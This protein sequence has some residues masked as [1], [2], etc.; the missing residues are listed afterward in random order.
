[1]ARPL[2]C[3]LVT[4]QN[5]EGVSQKVV[6]QTQFYIG[7]ATECAL[8]FA[9]LNISRHH[10]LVKVKGSKV[11][12][13]DQ[14]SSNGTYLNNERLPKSRLMPVE[15]G[16]RIRLGTAGA[17]MTFKPVEIAFTE[18]L[19][20][21]SSLKTEDKESALNMIHGAHAEAARLVSVG[22]QLHDKYVQNAEEKAAQ[23]EQK[24]A[25]NYDHVIGE[26]SKQAKTMVEQARAQHDQLLASAEQ[27]AENAT[28]A[29][30]ERM[31]ADAKARAART[32][33]EARLSA[34]QILENARIAAEDL[35]LRRQQEA[36]IDAR[37]AF[38]ERKKEIQVLQ[39]KKAADIDR[40]RERA[41]ES[42]REIIAQENAR[43]ESERMRLQKEIAD[44]RAESDDLG[45]VVQGKRGDLKAVE[46]Q[47]AATRAEAALA[48]TGVNGKQKEAAALEE[49]INALKAGLAD[50]NEHHGKRE[51]VILEV[52]QLKRQAADMLAAHD[53]KIAENKIAVEEDLT[54]RRKQ[55]EE[56]L[57]NMRVAE[58]ER[59][60]RE[61]AAAM[62]EL[63]RER[64]RLGQKIFVEIETAA[65]KSIPAE[66]WRRAAK[67]VEEA[68]LNNL[69][70]SA[71]SESSSEEISPLIA[72]VVK[73]RKRARFIHT[74]QGLALG[75]LI[76]IGASRSMDQMAHDKDPM[77]TAAEQRA[78]EIKADLERRKFNPP[79]DDQWRDTYAGCVIYTRDFVD[80][81]RNPEFQK[82][83]VK[84]A[85]AYFLKKWRVQEETVIEVTARINTLVGTLA[86]QKEKI[87][88]DHVKEGLKKMDD[89]E[90][91]TL[92]GVKD[93]LGSEVR[94][95][96]F[97]RLE[98]KTFLDFYAARQPAASPDKAVD[99]Q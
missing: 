70:P 90:S 63:S 2:S 97:R 18:A 55:M 88:P 16:D 20:K 36:E 33:D 27:D 17:E 76:V 85:S 1:M 9:D 26:A 14:G 15:P 52:D 49:Q 54:K 91:D 92:N 53:Q 62:S 78:K 19:L 25:A 44:L 6:T 74:L 69:Q 56:E 89:I 24:M 40:Y 94:V 21:E 64:A 67:A 68:V 38:E 35:A 7:R 83:W 11:W 41:E 65:V 10:V 96:A 47:L 22:K 12:V 13:E 37:K 43:Y 4:I 29:A 48:Q 86:E 31:K 32:I 72:E 66:T 3:L 28:K 42:A 57:T 58:M 8:S 60:K 61:R 81:Y 46:E 82:L 77:K 75:V 50:L 39:E 59:L 23:M 79:Q 5:F 45:P 99:K 93:L 98:K 84:T 71:I 80:N 30:V 34:A 73:E 87:H 51:A 95:E